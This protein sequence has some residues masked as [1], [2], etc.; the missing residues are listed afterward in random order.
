MLQR[1]QSAIQ[2]T[3]SRKHRLKLFQLV[4]LIATLLK[5]GLILLPVL[6]P[7]LSHSQAA[8]NPGR[9]AVSVDSVTGLPLLL[10]VH[11]LVFVVN[12]IGS[13][14]QLVEALW[15]NTTKSVQEVQTRRHT[16]IVLEEELGNYERKAIL[17][18]EMAAAE[19]VSEEHRKET[20]R[21]DG[22]Q[23]RENRDLQVLRDELLTTSE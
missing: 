3:T 4:K 19:A 15:E 18:Q 7:L 8:Q 23:E 21:I 13:K 20:F 16:I 1:R 2:Y 10:L 9:V 6:I 22:D 14:G 5:I 11:C 17:Q 12:Q